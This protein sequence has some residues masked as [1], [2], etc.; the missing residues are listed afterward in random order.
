KDDYRF[1]D[2]I[3]L[4][5]TILLVE[6]AEIP[7]FSIGFGSGHDPKALKDLSNVPGGQYFNAKDGTV[8]ENVFAAINERLAST[9]EAVYQ[10]PEETSIG[11]VPV[12]SFVID[13][14]GSMDTEDEE[15]GNRI[16]NVQNLI[17]QFVIG[18]PDE[19]QMQLTE[20]DDEI[21]IV[22]TLTT[23]KLQ[24]LRGLGRL[25]ASGGTDIVGSV[26]A[27]YKTLK[28]IPSSKKVLIYITDAA[29]G[30]TDSDNE[31]FLMLLENIKNDNIN[32]LWVGLGMEDSEEDFSLAA[33]ISGG[34]YIVTEDILLLSESFTKLLKTVEEIPESGLSNV[35]ISIDKLTETG[36]RESYSTSKL[37]TLSEVKKSYEVESSETIKY[38]MGQIARQYDKF[39]A[40]FISGDSLP[41]EET[42]ITKR[43]EG[44]KEGSNASAKIK[45]QE[46]IFMDK[47]NGVEAPSK[48][49]FM[50]VLMEMDNI[51]EAQEVM[52]YPD[53]SSHPASWVGGGN[54]GEVK[55]MKISYL[56]P[57]YTSHFFVSF[58]N[59]GSY[60][61]SPVTWLLEKPIAF[62]G[63]YSV[64][65][66]PDEKVKGSLV[67][68]VPDVPM[69]QL[70][71][72]FYDTNYGHIDIPLVGE[73]KPEIA[74][75]TSL[76]KDT[77]VKL[78]DVFEMEITG[79]E[80]IDKIPGTGKE[81]QE[82]DEDKGVVASDRAMLKVV[83][84][85]FISQMQALIN[86]NPLERINLKMNTE[87]G[88]FFIPINPATSLIPSGFINPRMISPG[89]QN[90]VRWLFEI[91]DGLSGNESEIF[92]DL[93]VED[94]SVK[95][96]DGSKLD[97]GTNQKYPSEFVDLTVNKLVKVSDPMEGYSGNYIIADITIHD[98]KDGYSS[99][100]ISS[101]LAAVND[102]YFENNTED[103]E[104]VADEGSK[105]LGNIASCIGSTTNGLNPSSLTEKLI[106][107]FTDDSIVYD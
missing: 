3:S 29:L 19:V 68:L 91:P 56:I 21:K 46:I 2:G 77:P 6:N 50:A 41:V 93:K 37:V 74:E 24:I 98:K 78:S 58:N 51:M 105:G 26:E 47:L 42:L 60:P 35:F 1:N 96:E 64:T 80:I 69:D 31:Y 34:E 66:M 4:E 40:E 17:R 10:R 39:T 101:L 104:P 49:R 38:T 16:R 82:T 95:V 94:Q 59:E 67:F 72:H 22:Q 25:E 71:L 90:I 61:A 52:V 92:V 54:Q 20:F 48:Y 32:A 87:S 12:V 86:I 14:S 55:L 85:N 36:A 107:G 89:S 102:A 76:P 15:N 57:D 100:D 18:L 43:M 5:E 27:S 79:I 81:I 73:M 13:T 11:D 70:S 75:V 7:L 63:N 30:T 62:P 99:A 33:E 88:A 8:L 83:E 106:L 28:E 23:E 9:F 44:E 103:E 53:G 97:S 45:A 65:I 84:A